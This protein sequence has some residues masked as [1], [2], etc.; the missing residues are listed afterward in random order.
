MMTE[1]LR[2]QKNEDAKFFVAVVTNSNLP[3]SNA[4]VTMALLRVHNSGSSD[5]VCVIS[6]RGPRW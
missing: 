1:E 4:I 3:R 6:Q 5:T 2:W